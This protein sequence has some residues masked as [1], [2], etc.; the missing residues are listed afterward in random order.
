MDDVRLMT[1]VSSGRFAAAITEACLDR[2]ANVWHIQP[3]SAQLPLRRFAEFALD[4]TDPARELLTP[5]RLRE[6]WLKKR[7]RLRL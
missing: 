4:A 6:R 5:D 7:D 2:G 1:N 3:L